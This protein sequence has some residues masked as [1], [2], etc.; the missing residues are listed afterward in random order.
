MILDFDT[1][2]SILKSPIPAYNKVKF[3]KFIECKIY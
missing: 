2:L 1:R 3:I